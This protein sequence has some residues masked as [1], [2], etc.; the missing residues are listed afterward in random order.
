MSVAVALDRLCRRGQRDGLGAGQRVGLGDVEHRHGAEEDALFAGL[1]VVVGALLDRDGGEDLDRL[2]AL[3]HAAIERKEGAEARDVA[4]GDVAGMALDRDQ[5][6]VAQ[7]V[8]GEAVGGAHADPALPAVAGQQRAGGLLD[9]LA[10]GLAARV[11]FGLGQGTTVAMVRHRGCS[12]CRVACAQ[13]AGRSPAACTPAR[14][15]HPPVA[16]RPAC[17]QSG[18]AA[19]ATPSAESLSTAAAA[20]ASVRWASRCA[21]SAFS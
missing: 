2:L 20:G 4:G 18:Y 19:S 10:V 16:G 8:A 7:A 14:A 3:A 13:C 9:A 5:P 6:L 1:L 11:A 17:G 21:A 12:W 15:C